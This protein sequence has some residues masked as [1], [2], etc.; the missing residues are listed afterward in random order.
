MQDTQIQDILGI[1]NKTNASEKP[2][3]VGASNKPKKK[4]PFKRAVKYLSIIPKD[5]K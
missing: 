5:P 2:S 3:V 4:M 1:L